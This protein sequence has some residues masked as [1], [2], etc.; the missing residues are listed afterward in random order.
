MKSI[1]LLLLLFTGVMFSSCQ[2][3]VFT[4]KPEQNQIESEWKYT[5]EITLKNGANAAFLR[6]CSNYED[7]LYSYLEGVD[8]TLVIK[9]MDENEER[10]MQTSKILPT[11]IDQ[12]VNNQEIGNYLF[13]EPSVIIQHLGCNL[14]PNVYSHSIRFAPKLMKAFYPIPI[15]AHENYNKFIGIVA[16]ADGGLDL[17]VKTMF[18]L[19]WYSSWEQFAINTTLKRPGNINKYT[20]FNTEKLRMQ[21]YRDTEDP[22]YPTY[23][24]FDKV[25]DFQRTG[26]NCLIGSYDGATCYVGTP[27]SGTTAFIYDGK[28]YYTPVNGNQ[29]PLAGSSYDGANCFVAYVP[30][31]AVPSIWN[32]KWYVLSYVTSDLFGKVE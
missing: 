27:P 6:I 9:S 23:Y 8:I 1:L 12:L 24:F 25:N 13:Q 4:D 30:E 29:C 2:K 15:V 20:D 22:I 3:D 10:I 31:F 32:N 7:S 26:T 28:F 18:K 17:Y 14:E 11:Q 5:K 21:L 19:Y 16:E